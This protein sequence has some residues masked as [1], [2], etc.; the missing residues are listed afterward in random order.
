MS[1]PA[2][3]PNLDEVYRLSENALAAQLSQVSALD[4]KA[5]FVL[6]SASILTVAAAALHGALTPSSTTATAPP[7]WI[8]LVGH[9]L[10]VIAVLAYLGV[11]FAAYKAYAVRTYKG[12]ANPGVLKDK[13]YTSMDPEVAKATVYVTMVESYKQNVNTITRKAEWTR[14][15]V[16]SLLVEAVLVAGITFIQVFV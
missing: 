4:S 7:D 12:V 13:G 14:W 11:V 15:A 5:N 2:R 16:R 10:A 3:W 9:I 1:T 8:V 6:T